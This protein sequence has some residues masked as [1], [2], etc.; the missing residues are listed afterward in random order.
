V[1]LGLR[2]DVDPP[3][4]APATQTQISKKPRLP[5][6]ARRSSQLTNCSTQKTGAASATCSYYN[7]VAPVSALPK[8]VRYRS[9]YPTGIDS[10]SFQKQV[11][12]S[13][14]NVLP[15]PPTI[16]NTLSAA[17]VTPLFLVNGCIDH[18]PG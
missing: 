18:N 7:A 15:L 8:T 12:E 16:M 9:R 11:V 10:R 13:F 1:F 6:T 3:R 14:P 4:A 17:N 5:S 2:E